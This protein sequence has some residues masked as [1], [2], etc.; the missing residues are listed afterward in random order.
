MSILMGTWLVSENG[1]LLN[2]IEN[3]HL[4]FVLVSGNPRIFFFF[5]SSWFNC[6][7]MSQMSLSQLCVSFAYTTTEARQP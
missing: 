6:L 3:E 5:F 4:G 2:S 7:T 1:L